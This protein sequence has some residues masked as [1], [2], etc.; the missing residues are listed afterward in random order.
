MGQ[1]LHGLGGTILYTVGTSWLDENVS[2]KM[3]PVFL[4]ILAGCEALG[5]LVGF[6]G[7]LF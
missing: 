1:I 2:T 7:K 4:G 3:A 6:G 5:K